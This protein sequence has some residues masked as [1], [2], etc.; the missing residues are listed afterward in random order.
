[1]RK[2]MQYGEPIVPDLIVTYSGTEKDGLFAAIADAASSVVRDKSADDLLAALQSREELLSTRLSDH[3]ALPHA[4]FESLSET[5]LVVVLCPEGVV[6][7]AHERSPVHLAFCVVGES[8]NHLATLSHVAAAIQP[9]QTMN[10]LVEAAKR[11]DEDQV[12][13]LL[14]AERSGIARAQDR[15]AEQ[16]GRSRRLWMHAIELSR[17]VGAR[18]ILL[19]ATPQHA[20][21]FQVPQD[22]AGEIFVISPEELG[23]P[24]RSLAVSASGRISIS[25]LYALSE[26]RVQKDDVVVAFYGSHDPQVPDTIQV[27]DVSSV[28]HLFF[29]VSKELELGSDIQ[30]IMLRV[31]ELAAEIAQEG[32]EGK[33][34]GALFVIGDL[35][36][37]RPHC[38]QM[39]I[40]PFKGYEPQDR[41]VLDPGLTETVK[42]LSRIDG[43]FVID[44]A[45]AIESAGT[46]LRV[47]VDV[48]DLP[49]GL[50]ARHTAA[51]AIT[52]V[53]EAIAVAVSESTRQVSIFRHGRRV[54]I[55]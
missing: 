48:A 10:E 49:S 11:G 19:H 39:L 15:G 23:V 1:M 6:Y 46:Y 25:L 26:Q 22:L 35:P 55:L 50:G 38:Q 41:N 31:I 12:A 53:S 29:S 32:R 42:E 33:P 27:A 20:K 34:T 28:F 18:C 36:A 43:A 40:N 3:I 17:S 5:T 13:A 24:R 30:R 45:G 8:A 47:D 51:A 44:G 37:V 7:D 52:A 54:L 2:A 14:G 9:Q 4:Q 21:R 16:H